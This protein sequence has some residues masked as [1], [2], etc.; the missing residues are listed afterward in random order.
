M[1]VKRSRPR[2]EAGPLVC[3]ALA[4]LAA[5]CASAGSQPSAA[6]PGVL[7]STL[8]P[9]PPVTGPLDLYVEYPDSLQ[10]I[11][12]SDTNFIHGTTG[13]GDATL[14]IDGAFV[15]VQPNGTFLAWLP[16][17]PATAGDTAFYQLVARRG[18]E[19]DT[20]RHPIL[21]PAVPYEGEPGTL[22]IDS[23]SV[24]VP[25]ERWALPDEELTLFFRGTPGMQ[26]WLQARSGT[27]V[28][29]GGRRSRS[30]HG[31]SACLGAARRRMHGR[32]VRLGG[33]DGAARGH[34]RPL[35]RRRRDSATTSSTRFVCSIRGR[36][37][38]WS[39]SSFPIR[40]AARTGS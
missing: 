4:L 33:R 6:P 23:A 25:A 29:G 31:A 9:I 11:A 22:W 21:L 24:S 26:A 16:V 38:S 34:V 40:S 36:F 1:N 10:R 39:W 2:A 30:L 7:E 18:S 35:G 27:P 14:I 8:P 32:R 17:P 37:R 12:V 28:D 19:V 3:A 20:L 13:T 15:E 5:G